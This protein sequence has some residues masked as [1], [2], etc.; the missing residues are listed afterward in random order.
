[1]CGNKIVCVFDK[2]GLDWFDNVCNFSAGVADSLTMGITSWL[3]NR[4]DIDQT[5]SYSS[6]SY[7]SGEITEFAVET[8]ITLG[9]AGLRKMAA[10]YAGKAGRKLL[11]P[12]TSTLRKT[13]GVSKQATGQVHHI[14]PIRA[15]RF[16]LPFKSSSK[17]WNL[18]FVEGVSRGYN[19]A[20]QNKHAYLRKLDSLDVFRTWSSPIR[21]FGNEI[22]RKVNA[23]IDSDTWGTDDPMQENKRCI[24]APDITIEVII[25]LTIEE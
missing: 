15:G 22:M 10:K 16:P 13:I 8:T 11:V 9:G 17:A 21:F 20:H 2:N 19:A 25:I 14:N 5:I 6:T 18:E 1:M 12:S 3:R 23:S 4:L 7:V 24:Y